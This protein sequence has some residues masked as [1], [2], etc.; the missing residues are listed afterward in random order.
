LSSYKSF[1]WARV[2]GVTSLPGSILT[3]LVDAIAG[4]QAVERRD[5]RAAIG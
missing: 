4:L 2:L 3:R 5:R 1:A